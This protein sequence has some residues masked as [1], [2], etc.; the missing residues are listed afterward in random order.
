[1]L[2]GEASASHRHWTT[3]SL[4]AARKSGR[5]FQEGAMADRPEPPP[6]ASACYVRSNYLRSRRICP[7]S[8]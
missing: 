3:G 4:T 5:A 1:M 7:D 2:K 8:L 6:P